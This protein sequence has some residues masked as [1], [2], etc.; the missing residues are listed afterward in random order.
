[1]ST[2]D[3]IMTHLYY[4]YNKPNNTRSKVKRAYVVCL[5]EW[6]KT[7]QRICPVAVQYGLNKQKGWNGCSVFFVFKLRFS[8]DSDMEFEVLFRFF[9]SKYAKMK[10]ERFLY[11]TGRVWL[12]CNLERVWPRNQ[13]GKG[14]V[15]RTEMLTANCHTCD[16]IVGA[17]H[18]ILRNSTWPYADGSHSTS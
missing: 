1:M 4:H 3:I 15:H 12:H 16:S 7:E 2:R 10:S 13:S 18:W 14:Q 9:S 17:E 11:G 8:W 5:I 6:M